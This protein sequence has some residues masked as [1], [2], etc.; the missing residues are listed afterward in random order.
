MVRVTAD[1]IAEFDPARLRKAREW[2]G[3]SGR[4]LSE[5]LGYEGLV[6][7]IERGILKSLTNEQLAKVGRHLARKG[8]LGQLGTQEVLAYILGFAEIE[9]ELVYKPAT[10]RSFP[11]GLLELLN[12]KDAP[13]G[14]PI[15]A[16]SGSD[17]QM[18]YFGHVQMCSNVVVRRRHNT[19]EDTPA[20]KKV[21]A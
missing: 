9:D 15:S 2:A 11:F 14:A 21:A 16:R 17:D 3:V 12:A 20:V 10:G 13:E 7:K 6:S 1:T 5:L 4:E 8:R 19:H 18:S